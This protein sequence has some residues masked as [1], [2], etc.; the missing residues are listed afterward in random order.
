MPENLPSTSPITF[1]FNY[2]SEEP[3]E[4]QRTYELDE[5]SKNQI[6]ASLT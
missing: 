3:K 6:E 1:V 2:L 5:R 4:S